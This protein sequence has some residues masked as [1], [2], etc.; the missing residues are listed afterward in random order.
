MPQKSYL[1]MTYKEMLAESDHLVKLNLT[2]P[3]ARWLRR[4]LSEAF[5]RHQVTN[6]GVA[7]AGT[8]LCVPA[9]ICVLAGFFAR[10][11]RRRRGA[12]RSVSFK[13]ARIAEREVLREEGRNVRLL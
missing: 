4:S 11:A 13:L 12:G 7:R 3:E 1:E 5:P 10:G 2:G 8:H 9:D 6:E